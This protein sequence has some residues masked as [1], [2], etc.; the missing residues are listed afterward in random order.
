MNWILNSVKVIVVVDRELRM[1]L[2][3]SWRFGISAMPG[4]QMKQIEKNI[5][6][7]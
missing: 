2:K 3:W 4:R 1:V 6:I 7:K 5:K